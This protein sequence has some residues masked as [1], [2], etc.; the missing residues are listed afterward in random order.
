MT[1]N[2]SGSPSGREVTRGSAQRPRHSHVAAHGVATT[3]ELAARPLV[4]RSFIQ[5]L[6]QSRGGRV[7]VGFKVDI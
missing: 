4:V 7:D 3:W 5:R 1:A 2:S 6:E